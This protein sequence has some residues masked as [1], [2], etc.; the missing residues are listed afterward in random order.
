MRFFSTTALLLILT[1]CASSP[2]PAPD[3]NAPEPSMVAA[4]YDIQDKS[5]SIQAVAPKEMV[6][7]YVICKAVWFAEK[8]KALEVSLSDPEYNGPL[9]EMYPPSLEFPKSWTVVDTTA[10]LSK[11][12]LAKNPFVKVTEYA[13]NCRKTWPWYH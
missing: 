12:K 8:K 9:K 7:E 6:R 10:Y 1:G 4:Y 5:F 13:A 3:T 2:K 11:N